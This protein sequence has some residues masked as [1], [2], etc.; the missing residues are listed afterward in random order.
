MPPLPQFRPALLAA[1]FACL[2]CLPVLSQA[3][4]VADSLESLRSRRR[5]DLPT[6][7]TLATAQT[8]V[9][10]TA[11]QIE[12]IL[13]RARSAWRHYRQMRKQLGTADSHEQALA[14]RAVALRARVRAVDRL[15]A[16]EKRQPT[17]EG[18]QTVI[19]ALNSLDR[20]TAA[21]E[22]DLDRIALRT[23]QETL[24]PPNQPFCLCVAPAFAR[25][26]PAG[27]TPCRPATKVDMTLAAGEA[28]G[29]QLVVVPYWERLEGVRVEVGN[30]FRR[31][32][33]DRLG[34]E[35]VR[36]WLTASA[37]TSPTLGREM[38]YPDPLTPA[39]PFDLPASASQAILVDIRAQR[40][41]PPGLYE[42]HIMVRA[43]NL[44]PMT[45]SLHIR[46]R[47]FAL[48]DDTS[49]VA[50]QVGNEFLQTRL[51]TTQSSHLART[52]EQF[53][54]PF[55]LGLCRE[56][57][58]GESTNPWLPLRATYA[59][60]PA[61]APS[62]DPY[63][64]AAP[65][66]LAYRQAG[67]A[68]WQADRNRPSRAPQRLVSGWVSLDPPPRESAEPPDAPIVRCRW[69]PEE[70]ANPPGLIYL[71]H[72]GR[73]EPTLRLVAI[74]DGIEDYRYL[75]LLAHRLAEAKRLKTARW[76]KRRRW[77]RLLPI[78]PKLCDPTQNSLEL[79]AKLL[80]RRE[81]IAAAIEQIQRLGHENPHAASNSSAR[82][83]TSGQQQ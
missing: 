13:R 75:E 58:P 7:P 18:P 15:L 21:V 83:I 72:L 63:S 49:R 10:Y 35:Q 31:D 29:F 24:L 45:V 50:F 68:A 38:L 60:P 26:P 20:A 34:P 81:A 64:L 1:L 54:A 5:A 41:Q 32:S 70:W 82:S 78:D 19:T 47:P 80:L 17:R 33:I 57:A 3:A 37:A 59:L 53:L 9:R 8:E 52:W 40:D 51:A 11:T 79:G 61:E 55:A 14:Q 66:S 69:S 22:Y 12:E 73:P 30:L 56:S 76:W 4:F 16:T 74:R 27:P 25:I 71:N 48:P 6:S 67:W 28:E 77:E 2:T 39:R 23:A 42:G 46:V 43:N 44:R 62:A 36:L 65:T